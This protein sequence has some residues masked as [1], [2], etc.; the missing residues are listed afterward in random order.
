MNI[1]RAQLLD[2]ARAARG[3]AVVFD[4]FRAT[5]TIATM[6]TGGAR[7]V[8]AVHS[9]D[10]ARR[11]KERDPQLVLAGERGGA[12]P[13]GFDLGNSPVE[14]ETTNLKGRT[15]VLTTSAGSKSIV[16]AANAAETVITGS[17]VNAG[18]VIRWLEKHC[19]RDVTLVA[20]GVGGTVATPEDDLAASYLERRLHG[21]SRAPDDL[22]AEIRRHP[23]ARKFLDPEQP[24]YPPA[25]LEFCLRVDVF[26]VV[27]RLVDGLLIADGG[28][29]A[30]Q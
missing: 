6:L 23:E 2:G 10:E 7:A 12:A 29:P 27:P 3:V 24:Q 13:A 11:W 26:D 20:A 9:V 4:V 15:V 19:P 25:D 16:A 21:D 17:F 14:A 22:F 5:T 28:L 8:R 18:S 30:E 1:H